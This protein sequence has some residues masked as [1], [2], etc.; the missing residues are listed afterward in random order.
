MSIIKVLT[1]NTFSISKGT[2]GS[3]LENCQNTGG[4]CVSKRYG[5]GLTCKCPMNTI[6]NSFLG[7]KG[8]IYLV[9]KCRHVFVVTLYK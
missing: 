5:D 3:D 9:I 8:I 1:F 7:C 4:V 6:Y 2:C